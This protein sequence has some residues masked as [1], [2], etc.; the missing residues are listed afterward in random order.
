V[1]L[2]GD[3]GAHALVVARTDPDVPIR[4]MGC[5]FPVELDSLA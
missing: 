1:D 4:M 5:C 3:Q 2:S